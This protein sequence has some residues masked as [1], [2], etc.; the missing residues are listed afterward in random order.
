MVG[1]ATKD[2]TSPEQVSVP[3]EELLVTVVTLVCYRV[4]LY[5][6]INLPAQVEPQVLVTTTVRRRQPTQQP[7]PESTEVGEGLL[8]CTVS[9]LMTLLYLYRHWMSLF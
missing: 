9:I 8:K 2:E 1:D 5:G 4:L 6:L 7:V 3:M